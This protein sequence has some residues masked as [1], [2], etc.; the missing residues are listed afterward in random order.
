MKGVLRHIGAVLDSPR[1][2]ASSFPVAGC[3]LEWYP[4]G[5]IVLSMPCAWA[6]GKLRDVQLRARAA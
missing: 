4:I 3:Y 6:G 2:I 5:L 1:P